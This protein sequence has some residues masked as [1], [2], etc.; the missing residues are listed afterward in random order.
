M[1]LT[2][3][4]LTLLLL[5]AFIFYIFYS[6]LRD[7]KPEN[8]MFRRPRPTIA[9]PSSREMKDCSPGSLAST[10]DSIFNDKK[11]E[12]VNFRQ[13]TSLEC[14]QSMTLEELSL[15]FEL[16]V[17]DFDTCKMIDMP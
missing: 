15:Q 7:I 11:N 4:L 2:K 3:Q 12:T 14:S 5:S 16:A 6:L 13:V 8:L 1:R 17:I 9:V 10:T